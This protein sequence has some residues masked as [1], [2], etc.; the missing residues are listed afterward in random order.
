[1]LFNVGE[2]PPLGVVPARMHA[3]TVRADRFGEPKDAF[4]VEVVDVPTTGPH[5]VLVYVMAAGVNYNN[6]WAARGVPVDVIKARNK[7]GE[8]EDFHIGGSDASGIVYAVGQAVTNVAVG[9]EVVVHCGMWDQDC[10]WVERGGDPMYSPSF[11]IWGYESNYGSFSQFTRVQAHQC[12][13]KP[14]H[15]SWEQAASYSLVGATAYRMLH[16]WSEHSLK[17]D[18]VVLV[19]GGAGG[20]GS[21]AIQIARAAGAIPVAIVS[22]RDKF[23]FCESLGAKG[24]IDRTE[25]DHWGMLPHWKDTVGYGKWLSGVRAFGAKLWDVLGERRSPNVVFEH[26]GE[27]TLPTSMFVCETGGTVVVCA[28]TT[29]YNATVDLRYLWMRQKRLQGSHFAN[30]DQ[31]YAMNHLATSGKLDPCMSR[32]FTFDELPTA[33]QLMHENQHPHGNMAVLIGASEFG[34]G[35]A[36]A[37]AASRH[38]KPVPTF[39]NRSESSRFPWSVPLPDV[40]RQIGSPAQLVDDDGARV[41]ELMTRNI[42]TCSP[43]D[44][45]HHAATLMAAHRINALVV[46]TQAEALGV[47]SQTDVVLARQGRSRQAAQALPVA[48]VMTEGC[49]TCDIETPLSDAVTTMTALKIH[50]LVVTHTLVLKRARIRGP[51][52]ASVAQ[53]VH[54]V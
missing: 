17:A 18:D 32:A 21:M 54:L 25:F 42:V 26:P 53:C 44:N 8:L 1:V 23:E 20:L 34:T 7:Q 47:I 13:P 29:G 27:S 3:W 41:S 40:M 52:Q 9:D 5:D 4:A 10:P 45:V 22:G 11:R 50:R 49:I 14:R 19:W 31:A 24:C 38:L 2:M 48:D 12:M 30:D 43:A 39:R 33:H 15:L 16:G 37:T 35:A 51:G 36:N 46:M 28:G 6:V